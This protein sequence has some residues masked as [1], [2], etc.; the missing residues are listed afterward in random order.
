MMMARVLILSA[1]R[2][3]ELD[4]GNALGASLKKCWQTYF[5]VARPAD[6]TNHIVVV[7]SNL[8]G[9]GFNPRF[10]RRT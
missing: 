9:S 5:V 4:E 1:L 3:A 7:A 8:N 2:F 10:P 6:H